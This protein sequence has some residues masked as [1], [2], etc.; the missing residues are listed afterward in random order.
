[1][2]CSEEVSFQVF[3]RKSYDIPFHADGPAYENAQATL[4]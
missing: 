2:G 1:M 4:C 3:S